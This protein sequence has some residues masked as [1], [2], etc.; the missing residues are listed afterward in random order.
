M[1]L[2]WNEAEYMRKHGQ[3]VAYYGFIKWWVVKYN[4][5]WYN[6]YNRTYSAEP[7]VSEITEGRAKYAIAIES[8]FL[9]KHS[10]KKA[11]K[12]FGWEPL[13]EYYRKRVGK[14]EIG[15]G[16]RQY[17][18]RHGIVLPYHYGHQVNH[19]IRYKN[20][21]Y[22]IG[23]AGLCVEPE[24]YNGVQEITGEE[25]K[26]IV[27]LKSTSQTKRTWERAQKLFGWESLDE[28]IAKRLE[29]ER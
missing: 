22:N 15:M 11:M 12:L 3:A 13:D 17:L 29:S 18:F 10:W 1:I 5:K 20:R 14:E 6:Y 19:I 24:Q 21:W 9:T 26:Y 8:R 7:I 23:Y 4:G 25:A 2:S 27:A 16:L 28:Y